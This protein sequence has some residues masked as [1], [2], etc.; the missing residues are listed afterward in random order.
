MAKNIPS[1]AYGVEDIDN[2]TTGGRLLGLAV[3]LLSTMP[4]FAD[5]HPDEVLDWLVAEDARLQAY[6]GTC[7]LDE[8]VLAEGD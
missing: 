1:R 2:T 7:P 4:Q 8:V 5:K 6:D 3:G